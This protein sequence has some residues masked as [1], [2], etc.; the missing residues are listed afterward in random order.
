VLHEIRH[1]AQVAYA[2]RQVAQECPGQH[3]IFY[4]PEKV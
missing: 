1:L 2:A 3:D 4:F